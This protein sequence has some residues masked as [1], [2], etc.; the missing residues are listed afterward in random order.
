[1]SSWFVWFPQPRGNGLCWWLIGAL[2]SVAAALPA[3]AQTISIASGNKQTGVVG[4]TLANSLVVKVKGRAGGPLA[5]VMITFA[6]TAGGGT[7]SPLSAVTNS[8]GTASTNLTLGTI[9]GTNT[10]T[11]TAASIG[12]VTFSETAIGGTPAKLALAPANA[13]TRTGVAVSYKATIQDIYGNTSTTA[14]NAVT[15][16]VSGVVQPAAS[17]VLSCRILTWLL[18]AL[19]ALRLTTPIAPGS[20]LTAAMMAASSA[21][22]LASARMP[23]PTIVLSN[24]I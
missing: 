13:T 10:V 6:V 1:M 7:V 9:A 20:A 19:A 22:A 16:S 5:G 4:T 18:A 23:S 3:Q 2:L 17:L 24:T 15:F 12:S 11:A 8:S 14:T 21:G